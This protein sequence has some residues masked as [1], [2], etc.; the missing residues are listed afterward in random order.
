MTGN[1]TVWDLP[2]YLELLLFKKSEGEK[3]RKWRAL[4]YKSESQKTWTSFTVLSWISRTVPRSIPILFSGR[5]SPVVKQ[6]WGLPGNQL[7]FVN[8]LDSKEWKGIM[9]TQGSSVLLW[10]LHLNFNIRGFCFF[11]NIC[12]ELLKEELSEEPASGS[13][14]PAHPMAALKVRGVL[15]RQHSKGLSQMFFQQLAWLCEIAA[16]CSAVA[17]C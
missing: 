9:K 6:R 13:Q 17:A 1:C 2:L 8:G 7:M 15:G 10:L 5:V 11:F 3:C 14:V 12:T 16:V 4:I